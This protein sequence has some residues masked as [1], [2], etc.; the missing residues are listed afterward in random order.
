MGEAL[1]Q[2]AGQWA[3]A[4]HA[5]SS[6]W[7]LDKHA[8]SGPRL[9]IAASG[10]LVRAAAMQ[11]ELAAALRS[12]LEAGAAC[13]AQGGPRSGPRS[14]SELRAAG[15]AC[16]EEGSKWWV[17]LADSLWTASAWLVALAERRLDPARPAGTAGVGE[18]DQ[19]GPWLECLGDLTQ[20]LRGQ[21]LKLQLTVQL[22][23]PAGP[24]DRSRGAEY[25]YGCRL[26]KA[27]ASWGVQCAAAAAAA[28]QDI[29]PATEALGDL[30]RVLVRMHACMQVACLY[31]CAAVH[32][33]VS[34]SKQA[35]S[36]WSSQLTSGSARRLII[37]V[38]Y[39]P[40]R[41][42]ACAAQTPFLV[43]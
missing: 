30:T 16:Q 7:V 12:S 2:L 6:W 33:T 19:W 35:S 4:C 21:A 38:V 20:L 37:I 18:P 39:C 15:A 8:P 32:G 27:L 3:S 14:G 22:E 5:W 9:S 36:N 26:A 1:S 25:S 13:G 28:G 11:H 23:G 31:G 29:L 24:A 17:A 41:C 34:L 40:F 10:W 43:P 42:M